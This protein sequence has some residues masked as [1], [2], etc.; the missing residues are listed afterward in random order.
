MRPEAGAQR[1]LN[2]EA[3]IGKKSAQNRQLL[4]TDI[5]KNAPKQKE[6]EEGFRA[7][8]GTA[9]L[10]TNTKNANVELDLTFNSPLYSRKGSCGFNLITDSQGDKVLY[11]PS[12]SNN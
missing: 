9:I 6:G 12:A 3:L 10:R 4:P 2:Q 5:I 1:H 7:P 11:M 8:P